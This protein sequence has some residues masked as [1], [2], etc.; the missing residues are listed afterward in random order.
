MFR[1]PY[2]EFTQDEIDDTR[3]VGLNTVL[4]DVDTRDWS[5]PGVDA[6][7]NKVVSLTQPGSIILHHDVTEPGVYDGD[8]RQTV[9]SLP[10]EIDYLRSHGYRFVT[11]SQL[12]GYPLKYKK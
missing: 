1:F 7:Y 8:R 5:K 10:R 9:A 12:L 2:G 3:E 4:W 11:V 6:I